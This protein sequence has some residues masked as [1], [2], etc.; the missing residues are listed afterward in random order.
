MQDAQGPVDAQPDFGVHLGPV[1][2]GVIGPE[3]Q[4]IVGDQGSDVVAQEKEDAQEGDEKSDG[5]H[6]VPVHGQLDLEATREQAFYTVHPP[7]VS[8]RAHTHDTRPPS[9]GASWDHKKG[10]E[11]AADEAKVSAPA[12]LGFSQLQGAFLRC[13]H[14]HVKLF[15]LDVGSGKSRLN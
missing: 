6:V 15:T 11:S 12:G 1:D 13:A 9:C 7:G 5:L 14:C 3:A 2:D 4:P 8:A 10:S